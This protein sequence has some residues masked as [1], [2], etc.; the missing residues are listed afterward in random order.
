MAGPDPAGRPPWA[1]LRPPPA[2]TG[3]S[4]PLMDAR[5]DPRSAD[6]PSGVLRTV[7]G[8]IMSYEDLRDLPDPSLVGRRLAGIIARPSS[9]DPM[10]RIR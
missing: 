1:R 2:P 4:S 3:A 9:L 7:R 8:Y 6:S 10:E 5:W